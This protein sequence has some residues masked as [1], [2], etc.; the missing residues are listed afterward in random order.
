MSQPPNQNP[1]NAIFE[2]LPENEGQIASPRKSE[3]TYVVS[4]SR[5]IKY[6]LATPFTRDV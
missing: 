1:E 4:S 3:R 6:K 5:S 2:P